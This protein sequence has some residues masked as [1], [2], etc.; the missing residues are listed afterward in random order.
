MTCS[1]AVQE[2]DE[3]IRVLRAMHSPVRH[4]ENGDHTPQ[5]E[6]RNFPSAFGVFDIALIG[7]AVFF[8]LGWLAWAAW[9]NWPVLYVLMVGL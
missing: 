6:P 9:L 5:S 4:I 8:T 7:A 3:A 1:G 2:T